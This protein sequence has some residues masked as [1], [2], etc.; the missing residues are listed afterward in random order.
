[1]A[2][3]LESYL[4]GGVERMVRGIACAAA[5]N[6][7][8]ARFMAEYALTSLRANRLRL[9]AAAR[10]EHVPPFLIASITTRCNLHCKGCYARAN[11]NCTDSAAAEAQLLSP[12]DWTRIFDEAAE[13]GVAFILLAGGE[14][15]M[16][17]E[18][19]RAAGRQRR[20][21]FPV[22]TN[23]T[24]LSGTGLELVRE[25]PNLMPVLSIEG[26]T[27]VTDARRGNGTYSALRRAMSALSDEALPFGCSVTVQKSNLH[28]V[29][30]ADFV[31]ELSARRAEFPELLLVSF[32]GDE[33]AMG[34]CLAAGRGFFHINA[35][36]GAEPCPFS[37]Y[38]DTS[39][40]DTSLREALASPL[41]VKLRESGALEETHVGGCT[42]FAQEETVKALCAE[43]KS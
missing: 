14:P 28:E 27:D 37:A 11:H 32:P 4:A 38:S 5:K 33:Q 12:D 25:H 2:F 20:I 30:G 9:D 23:G 41:F 43:G 13:L 3:D 21:I 26:G 17:P 10:G 35:Y 6:P 40:R 15:F 22:F 1:M 36:G 8:T 18:V 7:R 24:M 19:L 31:A 16:C 39:L 29:M 42:L 34:G